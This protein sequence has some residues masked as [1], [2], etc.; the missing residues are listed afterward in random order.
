MACTEVF[1]SILL[2]VKLVLSLDA[3]ILLYQRPTVYNGKVSIITLSISVLVVYVME[4]LRPLAVL[5]FF[6]SNLLQ[7]FPQLPLGNWPLH[8]S[9]YING[10][11]FIAFNLYSIS[12]YQLRICFMASYYHDSLHKIYFKIYNTVLKCNTKRYSA[13]T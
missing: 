11:I 6:N 5:L 8:L 4:G 10:N 3:L 12:R 9:K 7:S 13:S 2:H 1:I